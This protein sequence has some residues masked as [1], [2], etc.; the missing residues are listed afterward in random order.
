MSYYALPA[1]TRFWSAIITQTQG[2]VSVPATTWTYVSIQPPSGETWL[3]ELACYDD[4]INA[5]Y[6]KKVLYQDYDGTTA[7]DHIMHSEKTDALTTRLALQRILTN[8]LY[9]RIGFY[10]NGASTGYYGYSGFKLSKPLWTPKRVD[11]VA[12]GPK[13]WK[14]SKTA[15]LPSVLSALDKYAW[16]ILGLDPSKPN[17]YALGIILEENTPLA[18]DPNTGFPVERLTAVVQADVLADLIGKF[19]AGKEDPVATGYRKYLDK[20]KAEGINFGV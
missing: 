6:D 18:V 5:G 13:P 3:I 12:V 8:L 15:I 2:E 20:W 17:D 11:E 19:K 1:R 14:K 16:D 4:Y 7:R 10:T 9:A